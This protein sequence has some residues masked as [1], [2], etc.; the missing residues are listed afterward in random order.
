MFSSGLPH[1]I[2]HDLLEGVAALEMSLLL[3]HCIIFEKYLSLDDYNYRLVHFDYNYTENNKPVPIGKRSILTEGRALRLSASQTLLLIRILPFLIADVVPD[4]DSNWKC[5]LIL[6]KIVDIVMCP[7]SSADLCGILKL[8]IEDHHR[9][10]ITCYSEAM[11]SKFHYLL[12]YPKQ[13]LLVGPMLRTWNMRSEAKLNVFKQASRL[14]NFKNIALSVAHR[15]QRLLCYELSTGKLLDS[16]VQ[17]GPCGDPMSINSQSNHVQGSLKLLIPSVSDDSQISWPTW[18]K[19]LGTTIKRNAYVII[20]SD[21]L[22]PTFAKIVDILLLL[23]LVVLHV[24]F[25]DDHYHAYA[26]VP[27]ADQ[28]YVRFDQLTDQ[29]VLHTHKKDGTLYIYLPLCACLL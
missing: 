28:S 7:W 4:H 25:F 26:V 22:H 9:S 13:V 3:R 6:S 16:P 1:D 2:M 15:H 23:D 10:F 20:G 5:F 14:G 29:S 19:V 21:G 12:H 18:V 17:C 11:I 24:C 27:S 8:L